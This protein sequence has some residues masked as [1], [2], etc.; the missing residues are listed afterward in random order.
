MQIITCATLSPNA[1]ILSFTYCHIGIK[2][3]D[4]ISRPFRIIIN[5]TAQPKNIKIT[6]IC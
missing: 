6:K 2:G 4:S 3:N 5:V 1:C